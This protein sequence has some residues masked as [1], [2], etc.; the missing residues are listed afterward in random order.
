MNDKPQERHPYWRD[1]A[2]TVVDAFYGE[3]LQILTRAAESAASRLG[4]EDC[5]PKDPPTARGLVLLTS[6]ARAISILDAIVAL[7]ETACVDQVEV[8]LRS[9]H[10]LAADLFLVLVDD[11]ALDSYVHFA[12]VEQALL[13]LASDHAL[14][15]PEGHD[16]EARR[17]ELAA[18]LRARLRESHAAA[19]AAL[20]TNADLAKVLAKYARKRF[21]NRRPQSWKQ[22]YRH[23]HGLKSEDLLR[24]HALGVWEATSGGLPV[25]L[26]GWEILIS[27]LRAERDM[28]YKH[29]SSEVHN[30]PLAMNRK[31]DPTTLLV[32]IHGDGSKGIAQAAA[33]LV[34]FSRIMFAF[35]YHACAKSSR[36]PWS[37]LVEEM[38]VWA[39]D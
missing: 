9:L 11:R 14:P 26:E 34:Q 38:S 22:E 24:T 29:W 16:L 19:D 2:E 17:N 8:M 5:R 4:G 30:S 18:E 36:E 23:L 6:T 15:R 20:D 1:Q 13:A 27:G 3:A 37:S 31:L 28:L 33:A 25:V 35:E 32:S 39:A 21:G 7:L 12:T 10:E